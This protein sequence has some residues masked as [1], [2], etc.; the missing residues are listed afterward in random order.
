MPTVGSGCD[1]GAGVGRMVLEQMVT[2]VQMWRSDSGETERG[3]TLCHLLGEVGQQDEGTGKIGDRVRV[4]DIAN[5][6]C[7]SQP[8]GTAQVTAR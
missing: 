8:F 4:G 3:T 2:R 6:T 5:G 1:N 7:V